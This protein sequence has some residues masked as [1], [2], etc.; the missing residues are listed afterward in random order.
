VNH[1]RQ[2][3]RNRLHSATQLLPVYALS[4]STLR[5]AELHRGLRFATR[6]PFSGPQRPTTYS[7]CSINIQGVC[8]CDTTHVLLREMKGKMITHIEPESSDS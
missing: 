3:G 1:H 8:V 2:H 4:A 5:L 7:L 6:R